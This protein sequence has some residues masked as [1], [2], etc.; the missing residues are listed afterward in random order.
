LFN[1]ALKV[2]SIQQKDSV[3][4]EAALAV[5][6][7]KSELE[8]QR[9]QHEAQLDKLQYEMDELK[10]QIKQTSSDNS[11]LKSSALEK[12]RGTTLV[13]PLFR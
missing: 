6:N 10:K 8:I 3:S 2:S 5:D 7:F 11:S 4:K 13:L 9:K 12:K 1:Q